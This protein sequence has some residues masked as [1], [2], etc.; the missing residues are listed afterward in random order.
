MCLSVFLAQIIGL[1]LVLVG[2][3]TLIRPHQ[4]KK[5]VLEF[6]AIPSLIPLS[7]SLNLLLGLLI[8]IPHH[9]WVLEWPLIITVIGWIFI[10]QGC[11]RLFFPKNFI[12]FTKRLMDTNGFLF[13][14]WITF[15][16]GLYLV[17]MGLTQ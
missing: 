14:S 17:W 11:V 7:G 9:V 6:I 2:L 12:H 3:S 10:L 13:C 15:L 5:I 1:Y 16:A 4:F 8:L